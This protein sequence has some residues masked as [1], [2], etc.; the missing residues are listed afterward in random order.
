VKRAYLL[1]RTETSTLCPIR[2]RR[3]SHGWGCY[4]IRVARRLRTILENLIQ[5]LTEERA[6]LLR[7]GL[8]LLCRVAERFFAE[9]E[10]RALADIRDFQGVGGKHGHM[11]RRHAS[12]VT[13]P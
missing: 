8:A 3:F 12:T 10:D 1:R 4:P 5:S 2:Y 9:P 6:A 11:S 7:R 13:P